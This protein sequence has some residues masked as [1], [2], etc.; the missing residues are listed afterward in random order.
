M[1]EEIVGDIRDE[2]DPHASDIVKETESSWIVAGNTE[3]SQI[4]QQL[5]VEIEPGDYSTVAGL[6]LSRLGQVPR[7]GEK[8]HLDDV[9]LEVLEA[10]HRTV[11]KVR[12]QM[13]R[14]GAAPSHARSNP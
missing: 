9:S 13:N 8:L 7:A 1:V 10:S 14:P 12:L 2:V 11:V 3:L 6:L 4:T 5:K